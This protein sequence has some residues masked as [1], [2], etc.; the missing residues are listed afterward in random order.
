V[1]CTRLSRDAT[2]SGS[3]P[4]HLRVLADEHGFA[5]T[6]GARARRVSASGRP[7]TCQKCIP[8]GSSV[9]LSPGSTEG[10]LSATWSRR[11]CRSEGMCAR[12]RSCYWPS[13]PRSFARLPRRSTQVPSRVGT[14]AARHRLR[15]PPGGSE[16]HKGPDAGARLNSGRQPWS[17]LFLGSGP[18]AEGIRAWAR[19]VQ[20]GLARPRRAGAPRRVPR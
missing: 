1:K 14:G 19:G 9:R 16:G 17:A 6:V 7:R 12:A 20:G 10:A 4:R 15:R 3:E 11:R 5:A 8:L 18:E 13:T 2:E